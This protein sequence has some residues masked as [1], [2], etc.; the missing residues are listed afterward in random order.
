[1]TV[2]AV[3][4]AKAVISY[5]KSGEGGDLKQTTTIGADLTMKT[6]TASEQQDLRYVE[7]AT[8]IA[9]S[10]SSNYDLAGSLTDDAGDTI[11]FVEVTA[12]IV[13]A[14]ADNTND[15]VIGGAASNGFTGPFG[16]S[17]HTI[18]VQPGGTAMLIAPKAGWTVTAGTGD[19]LKIANSG[20]GS[21]VVFDLAILGRSA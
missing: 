2:Q 10:S 12:I 6:G 21:A 11:T 1:M 4:S 5:V 7:S 14:S 9:A 19:I 17:T 15:V 16:G 18:A 13:K 8:S 3:L 20:S